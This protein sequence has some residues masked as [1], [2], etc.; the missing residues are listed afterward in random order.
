VGCILLAPADESV[1]AHCAFRGA[2]TDCGACLTARCGKQ[3]DAAC[4]SQAV[5]SP[6]EQC[7]ADG[8]DACAKI[9]ASDVASC[10]TQ[11]CAAVCYQKSGASQTSCTDSFLGPGLACSCQ[12]S[13]AP[14]DLLCSP[15]TY[16]RTRCCAPTAWP[17]PALSCDCKA[18][19][20]VSTSDGCICNLTDNLDS[21]TAEECRGTHCCATEDRCQ[22]RQR[23]CEGG[24]REVSV[25]NK[26]ELSCPQG[27]M[28][29][30]SCSIRR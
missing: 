23:A 5:L 14:N 19:A 10:L 26:A 1:G 4:A 17:G 16:P 11:S 29:V 13:S 21:V 2:T 15:A 8:T 9:P 12:V 7:A 3:I 18:V 20:C 27:R 6:M 24:E 25:C 28:E 22:C 30:P